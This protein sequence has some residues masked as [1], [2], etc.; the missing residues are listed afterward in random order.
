VLALSVRAQAIV[1]N[2]NA[3]PGGILNLDGTAAFPTQTLYMVDFSAVDA[4]TEISFSIRED[5]GYLALS[6][7]KVVAVPPPGGSPSRNLL[8]NGDFSLGLLSTSTDWTYSNP[9]GGVFGGVVLPK[10]GNGQGNCWFDGPVG[11]YD[12][13]SQTISTVVGQMYEVSFYLNSGYATYQSYSAIS[14]NGHPN[15]VFGNGAN[16]VVYARGIPTGVIPGVPEASTWTMMLG[17]FATLGVLGFAKSR[18]RPA[19]T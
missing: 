11:G 13:L 5:S 16:V 4:L 12:S 19:L 14:T 17:G 7:T 6:Q 10:C 1:V 8:Q 18:K 15:D 9:T 2:A 3:D